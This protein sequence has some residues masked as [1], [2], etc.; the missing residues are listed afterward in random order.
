VVLGTLSFGSVATG[1]LSA[2]GASTIPACSSR[3]LNAVEGRQGEATTAAGNLVIVNVSAKSCSLKGGRIG[4]S[5]PQ[6][7]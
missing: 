6:V 4:V 3:L 2:A 5:L 1:S 7:R